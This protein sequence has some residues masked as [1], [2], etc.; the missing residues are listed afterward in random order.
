MSKLTNKEMKRILSENLGHGFNMSNEEIV[1]KMIEFCWLSKDVARGKH[2]QDFY[3]KC[4][5][6]MYEEL[7]KI[8]YFD[9]CKVEA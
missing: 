8:G 5:H 4:A 6:N 1:L 7:D 2:L 9:E 3:D